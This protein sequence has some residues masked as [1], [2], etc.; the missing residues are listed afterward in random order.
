M[1]YGG[2]IVPTPGRD[3][4]EGIS[5]GED[6]NDAPFT[7]TR[8]DIDLFCFAGETPLCRAVKYGRTG[9]RSCWLKAPTQTTIICLVKFLITCPRHWPMPLPTIMMIRIAGKQNDGA[10][11]GALLEAGAET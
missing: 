1:R 11:P 3:R 2:I 7:G 4:A 10:N 8:C 5:T 6:T 9:C